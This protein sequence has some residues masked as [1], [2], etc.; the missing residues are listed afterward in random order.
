V[1]GV[2]HRKKPARWAESLR[3][4]N[5]EGS[6]S[7]RLAAYFCRIDVARGPAVCDGVKL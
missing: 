6:L 7:H 5:C 4:K 3:E 2:G 1:Q